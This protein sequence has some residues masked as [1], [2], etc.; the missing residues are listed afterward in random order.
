MLC[1]NEEQLERISKEKVIIG[2]I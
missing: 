1:K 2:C